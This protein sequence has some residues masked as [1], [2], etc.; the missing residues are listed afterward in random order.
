MQGGL[1]EA[2]ILI[3]NDDGIEA[4]GIRILE[5]AAL[6]LSSDVWV[7]APAFEQ[8]GTAHSFTAH[9]RLTAKQIAERRFTV[10]GTPTDCVLFSCNVLFKDRRPDMVLSGINHGANMGF[11]I[12]YSGTAGAAIEG[13]LQGIKSFAFSLYGAKNASTSWMTPLHFVPEIIER[14]FKQEWAPLSFLNVNF[15]DVRPDEV[16]GIEVT[17]LGRRKIGDSIENIIENGDEYQFSI[18]YSRRGEIKPG[19]DADAVMRHAV[20]VTPVS[21]DLMSPETEALL[22]AVL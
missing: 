18:G 11:D 10:N 3:C 22:K 21:F 7:V 16:T 5:Q 2:R 1:S 6:T 13:A 8:S 15:P 17:A 9:S 14:F 19:T 20:S 4:E 12:V